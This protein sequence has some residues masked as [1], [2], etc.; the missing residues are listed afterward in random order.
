MKILQ[1]QEFLF[2]QFKKMNDEQLRQLTEKIESYRD[3]I[4]SLEILINQ[5]KEDKKQTKVELITID[6]AIRWLEEENLE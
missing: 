2:E 1:E 5:K 4:L 3:E 6:E